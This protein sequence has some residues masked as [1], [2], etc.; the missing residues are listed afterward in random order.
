MQCTGPMC[1]YAV[2]MKKRMKS[3]GS[4]NGG[5]KFI[6][7]LS[8]IRIIRQFSFDGFRLYAGPTVPYGSRTR[9]LTNFPES[10]LQLSLFLRSSYKYCFMSR[11]EPTVL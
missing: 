8:N 4:S 10:L 3:L 1:S 7:Y 5:K 2:L 6:R 9:I 11:T